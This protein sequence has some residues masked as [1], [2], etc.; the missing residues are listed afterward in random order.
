MLIRGRILDIGFALSFF[1]SAFRQ[2]FGQKLLNN[3]AD[4]SRTYERRNDNMKESFPIDA[5]NE[6]Y[7]AALE[8]YAST[9]EG[10][11]EKEILDMMRMIIDEKNY[12]LLH[13]ILCIYDSLVKKDFGKAYENME[14]PYWSYNATAG[15][16][17]PDI[18]A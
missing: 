1:L 9:E 13:S 5:W 2:F 11:Y 4:F 14:L 10:A 8:E 15:Y 6:Y 17:P 7:V 12:F 16:N 18:V 3:F